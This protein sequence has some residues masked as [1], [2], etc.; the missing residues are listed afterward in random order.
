MIFMVSRKK[1]KSPKTQTAILYND[2]TANLTNV[3]VCL[4]ILEI[5][6]D[7]GGKSNGIYECSK[8]D[9]GQRNEL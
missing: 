4:E 1:I 2:Q 7:N 9:S 6:S 5:K 8:T 3:N